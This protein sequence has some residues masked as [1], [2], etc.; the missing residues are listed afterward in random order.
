M[1]SKIYLI[2]IHACIY[3]HAVAPTIGS[4]EEELQVLEGKQVTLMVTASGFPQPTITWAYQ[5]KEVEADYAT[6]LG[7]DGSLT[8]VCVEPKHGGIYHFTA[9][10][11]AGNAEGDVT[12]IIYTDLEEEQGNGDGGLAM[13]DS[14]PMETETF[15]ECV[16]RL[17]ACNNAGFI[18]QYQ[19]PLE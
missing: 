5:G 10:N 4:Y 14:S 17:H 9:S 2:Y 1:Q 13:V 12:L 19:V 11:K 3:T 18:L 15:G 8:L 16:S 7:E 6:E